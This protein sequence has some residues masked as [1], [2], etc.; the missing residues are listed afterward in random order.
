[1]DWLIEWLIDRLLRW[2]IDWLIERQT[3]RQ[4][5]R[6]IIY[7]ARH[8][9]Q[10]P[11]VSDPLPLRADPLRPQ[12]V[13][14]EEVVLLISNVFDPC[15]LCR[16]LESWTLTKIPGTHQPWKPIDML[17]SSKGYFPIRYSVT[18]SQC[19]VAEPYW[20]SDSAWAFARSCFRMALHFFSSLLANIRCPTSTATK[21]LSPTEGEGNVMKW[22]WWWLKEMLVDVGWWWLMMV[23][24]FIQHPSIIQ[25]VQRPDSGAEVTDC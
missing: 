20:V 16:I 21:S 5:D 18:V 2:L 10:P 15:I 23:E 14:F 12:L 25:P 22:W 9:G 8:T 7:V 3:D 17:F 6:R 11:L 24:M 13:F 19:R 1:M 4:I